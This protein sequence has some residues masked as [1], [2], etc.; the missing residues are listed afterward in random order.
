MSAALRAPN[1]PVKLA[2]HGAVL[3]GSAFCAYWTIF[4]Q[5]A[6]FDDEGYHTW[7]LR[8]FTEGHALYNDVFT[9]Y[10]PFHYELWGG[11]SALTGI[12]FSTDTGRIVT[13]AMW[14]GTSLLLGTVTTRLTHRLSLGV[15]VQIVS[16]SVLS[17]F[18]NEP[19][20]PGD[21]A[22]CLVLGVLAVAVFMS[23]RHARAALFSIG[24]LVGAT[25]LTKINVGGF[26][27]VAVVYATATTLPQERWTRL[28][29]LAAG[30]AMVL[31]GL[32]LMIPTLDLAWT[33]QYAYLF[34][35]S[36]V[37]LV[38]VGAR[39][40]IA[41]AG[42]PS[43][44]QR[45]GALA[46]G[47]LLAIVLILAVCF[48][49]G[50]TPG[51]LYEAVVVT[52]SHQS[53]AFRIAP[54]L[55]LWAYVAPTA[56]LAG[57]LLVRSGRVRVTVRQAAV[58][59]VLAGMALWFAVA[60]PLLVGP[61]K[62]QFEFALP[63]LWVAAIPR[64]GSTRTRGGP[65][66]RILVPALALTQ[67][68]VGY[69]VA[70]TQYAF[71]SVLFALCGAVCAADGW[72]ELQTAQTLR[73][74]TRRPAAAAAA[75]PLLLTA[76]ALVYGVQRLARPARTSRAAYLT[77]PALPI[78]GAS[79]LHLP[80]SQVNE[81]VGVV[82]SL[83]HRCHTLITMPGMFSFNQWS[84]LPNPSGMSQEPWWAVL[85]RQ[86]LRIALVAAQKADD[87]CL[88][89]NNGSVAFWLLGR[90]LPQIPLVRYLEHRFVQVGQFGPY[91]TN[92]RIKG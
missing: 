70:G 33:Q 25:V 39:T 90:P 35:V 13:L 58:L 56:G 66:L 42:G 27:A 30:A 36:S 21:T 75:I 61:A 67:S 4:S 7:V 24:A 28:L 73:L 63:L 72:A 6:V 88:V 86:Q 44:A 40:T 65:F 82:A 46:S 1:R 41:E 9:Y 83:R 69:P 81:L 31:V 45:M 32:V 91:T 5:F 34:T 71:G 84:G 37:A 60:D 68:L 92:V 15:I 51:A 2:V 23:D 62:P 20:Y 3:A 17:S 59:R 12:T 48:A 57:A 18:K 8:L 53:S 29:R 14:L 54:P 79:D 43:P 47:F 22:L 85:S 38:L 19:M 89:R 55:D 52:A 50:S 77:Q 49:L 80:R 78:P 26:A 76:L 74:P 64:S 10:G 87:L 11:L 16:F